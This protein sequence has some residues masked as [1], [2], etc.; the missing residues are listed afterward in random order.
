MKNIILIFL[1]IASIF[2]FQASCDRAEPGRL[3]ENDTTFLSYWYFPNDS[4]WIYKD[5]V[6]NELDTFLVESTDIQEQ[7]D[8]YSANKFQFHVCRVINR[9]VLKTQVGRPKYYDEST[10]YYD[11]NETWGMA[12]SAIRLFYDKYYRINDLENILIYKRHYDSIL[13]RNTIYYDVMH[14][15]NKGQSLGDSIRQEYYARNIGVIKRVY[16]SNHVWELT[17]F[18]IAK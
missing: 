9:G 4:Y 11:V 15:T 2:S 17:E 3:I 12:S 18:Q 5:S 16:Q 8:R 14:F 6:T 13:I 10:Y 7:N 1:L